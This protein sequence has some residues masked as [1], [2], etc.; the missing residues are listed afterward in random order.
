MCTI[1]DYQFVTAQ[2]LGT[3]MWTAVNLLVMWIAKQNEIH[4]YEFSVV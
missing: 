4:S 1:S 2:M 3:H